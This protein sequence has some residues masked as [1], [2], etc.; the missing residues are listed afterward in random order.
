AEVFRA[1][2]KV[3]RIPRSE[4]GARGDG[5]RQVKDK[6]DRWLQALEEKDPYRVLGVSPLDTPEA[7]RDRYRVLARAHHPDRGGSA[8]KMRELNAAYD[9]IA[10]HRERRKVELLSADA[11]SPLP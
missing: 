8:E 2:A 6:L 1:D 5:F 3:R 4:G 9:R 11:T 7:I 10:Q